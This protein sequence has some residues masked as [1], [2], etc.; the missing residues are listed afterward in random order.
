MNLNSGTN[1][2]KTSTGPPTNA[3]GHKPY[4][5]GTNSNNKNSYSNGRETQVQPQSQ[6]P[7]QQPPIPQA[8]QQQQQ[9]PPPPATVNSIDLN[10]KNAPFGNE[11][12]K[13]NYN[14]YQIIGFQNKE[15]NEYAKNILKTQQQQ[16][17]QQ[18]P[19]PPTQQL[20]AGPPPPTATIYQQAAPIPHALPTAITTV[21]P[22][23]GPAVFHSNYP[24]MMQA[25]PPMTAQPSAALV[26]GKVGD[27]C[28][29]KY[30]EDGQVS[31]FSAF[32]YKKMSF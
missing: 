10:N 28:L 24:I 3:G 20:S 27:F 15:T 22:T 16:Q 14:P 31:V 21:I 6:P 32:F 29:A 1:V 23:Q 25:A 7:Q 12:A 13:I 30:W 17:Q 8:P 2:N 5:S 18:A 9:Q 26:N 11:F 19:P 4:N